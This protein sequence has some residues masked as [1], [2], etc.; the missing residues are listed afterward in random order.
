M[1]SVV[2]QLDAPPHATLTHYS[3]LLC[4]AHHYSLCLSI[5]GYKPRAFY[6]KIWLED[7]LAHLNQVGCTH[8]SI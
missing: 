7:E 3:F 1:W 8:K 6:L 4:H 2:D 5:Q